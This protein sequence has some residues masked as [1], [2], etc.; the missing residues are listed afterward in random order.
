MRYFICSSEDV[1]EILSFVSE[2]CNSKGYASFSDVPMNRIAE[3]N[4]ELSN[5]ALY[6]AI[7]IS[8]LKGHYYLNDKILTQDENRTN[9]TALLKN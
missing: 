3:E 8:I 4:Y 1:N 9:M 2:E 5:A 6:S 7:Y